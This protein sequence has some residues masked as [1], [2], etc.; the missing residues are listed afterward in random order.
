MSKHIAFHPILMHF[1]ARHAGYS[2]G[3]FA[4]DYRAL[5]DSN[6]RCRDDFG[7]DAVGVISDPYRETSAFGAKVTFPDEA[8]PRCMDI[9]VH[10]QEDIALLKNPDVHK[11]ERTLDRI[12]GAEAL[13]KQ[14]GNEVPV[15]GWIEGPLAESCDLA[16]VNEILLKIY[17]EP[18]FINRLMDKVMITAKDFARAQV[19]AGCDIIGVGDAIC[20]QIDAESYRE[21]V[22]DRQRELFEYIQSL[23]AKVKLHICG[24]ITHL[25]EDIGE[26]KP[27]IVD[28]DWMVDMQ[29]AYDRLG[30][31]I[32]RCGNLDPVS[33]IQDQDAE[34]IARESEALCRQEA[35]RPFILSGGCEITV[36]TPEEHLK[37]MRTVS[38]KSN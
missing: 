9:V 4:S 29:E 33:I 31:C 32:V 10:S 2:Y 36:N 28:I 3:Q 17:M 18:D 12:M 16:G 19:E 11:E 1:A 15:I 14:L 25:L 22:K 35:G 30:E 8:V 24:N 37:A 20:S 5:V 6:I 34:A 26:L 27:D 7:M 23:G 38:L 21:L 13:R